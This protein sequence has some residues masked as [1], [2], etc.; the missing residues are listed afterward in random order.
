MAG[1]SFTGPGTRLDQRLNPD[2]TPK[3]WSKPINRIDR[4]AYQ[5][6]LAYAKHRDTASRNIADRIMV[7]QLN[8]IPNPTLSNCHPI[9][10]SKKIWVGR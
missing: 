10:A 6:D 8:S 1:H 2:L 7:N 5:H 3:E 9:L 4:A